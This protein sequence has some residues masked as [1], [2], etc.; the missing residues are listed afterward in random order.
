MH[1]EK[2][3]AKYGKLVFAFPQE[4]N[5]IVAEGEYLF[6][7]GADP[8]NMFDFDAEIDIM[9]GDDPDHMETY[10]INRPCV[11]RFP[12]NV[13]HCPIRFRRMRK[14]LLFQA[15]FQDGVWGTIT[16]SLPS[17]GAKQKQYFSRKYT[18]D[19]M[20]DNVRRCKFHSEK[21]CIVCG[22]C[23]PRQENVEKDDP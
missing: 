12:A 14:P 6:F 16:R 10:H 4:R 17:E 9:I 13:W 18:Y 15:A 20:C 5:E 21:P 23:F 7:T 2:E 11:I 22:K 8:M 3:N 19:Y 1:R